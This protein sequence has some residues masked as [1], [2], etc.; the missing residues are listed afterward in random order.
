MSDNLNIE[1][2]KQEYT[3]K[4]KNC[5]SVF[6]LSPVRCPLDDDILDSVLG[7]NSSSKFSYDD[8]FAPAAFDDLLDGIGKSKPS[9]KEERGVADFDP[10]DPWI[11]QRVFFS[12]SPFPP[13]NL[14][15]PLSIQIL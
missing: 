3:A 12:V 15:S 7:L 1:E 9:E 13:L 8:V 10:L 6:S 11:R 5:D 2:S 14:I 4:K